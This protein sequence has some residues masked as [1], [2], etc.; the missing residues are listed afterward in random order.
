MTGTRWLDAG[1]QRAWRSYLEATQLL[2]GAVDEQLQRE[3]GLSHADYEIL[4]RLSEA[5]GRRMRM[6]ELAERLLFSRSRLSHAAAR[7]EREGWL[8]REGCA[9]DKRGTIAVLSEEGFAK[10]AA[11]APGHVAA[12]RAGLLDALSAEQVDQLHRI[13]E[14]IRARLAPDGSGCG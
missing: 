10:L 14:G 11:T 1:E 13:S 8:R 9:T 4:V 2:L 3:A 7:L 6:A 5:P 12:V